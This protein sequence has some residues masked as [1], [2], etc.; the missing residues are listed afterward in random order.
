MRFRQKYIC[1]SNEISAEIYLYLY[2]YQR[3]AMG[4]RE[5]PGLYRNEYL[6]R[7]EPVS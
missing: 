6:G 7:R 4:F 3:E 2:L 1:I 5:S